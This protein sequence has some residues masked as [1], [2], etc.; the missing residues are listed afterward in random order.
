MDAVTSPAAA[1]DRAV[2]FTG[3]W[4]DFAKIAAVNLGLTI[5]TL[6]I[7]RFWATAR[8]RRYLW[9]NS[10]L[11]GSDLEWTG[12]GGEMFI[13]FLM[14]MGVLVGWTALIIGG[15]LLIGEW[16]IFLGMFAFYIFLLWAV[17]FAQFRALRYRLSRT[18]WRGI[19][20]G[21]DD[22]GVHYGWTALGNN[23]LAGI[24]LG[25]MTP[26]ALANNWNDRMRAM[27]FGPHQ[28]DS[29]V[30]TVGLQSRWMMIYP[31]YI[32]GL[33]LIAWLSPEEGSSEAASFIVR[34]LAILTFV[35]VIALVMIHFWALFFRKAA[36]TF[37]MGG[38]TA[39]F[40]VSTTDWLKFYGK[41]IGLTIITLGLGALMWSYW[42]W[43]FVMER[44]ALFGA[45]D[46]ESMTQSESAATR[47]AEGFADAFDIGAF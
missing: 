29:N 46:A 26:A 36:D 18:Y 24:T 31:A 40:E 45:I 43:E 6:G 19:R 41:I 16:F 11:V 44:L 30:D 1:P 28:F 17:G 22:N 42:R 12:T 20:G 32:G 35:A 27:S 2:E 38:L 7:Y 33:V 37:E 10:R 8:V 15:S 21:S 4:Q 23:I 9:S 25:I 5:I 39:S 13:G 3:R 14:V 47:D 34:E